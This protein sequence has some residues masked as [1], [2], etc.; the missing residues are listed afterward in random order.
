MKQS[1]IHS[2]EE[3]MNELGVGAE[4]LSTAPPALKSSWWI[5]FRKK[6]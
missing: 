5:R 3:V 4:G 2:A 1:Y 6:K